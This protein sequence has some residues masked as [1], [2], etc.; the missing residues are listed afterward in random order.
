MKA[1]FQKYP[2]GKLVN[3]GTTNSSI[4]LAAPPIGNPAHMLVYHNLLVDPC[5][6]SMRSFTTELNKRQQKEKSAPGA[7]HHDGVGAEGPASASA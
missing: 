1:G 3:E 6:V 7:G 4:V 2:I 5:Q